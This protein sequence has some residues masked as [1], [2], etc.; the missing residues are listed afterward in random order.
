MNSLPTEENLKKN[1]LVQ[2][3][4]PCAMSY[5]VFPANGLCRLCACFVNRMLYA[6]TFPKLR[7]YRSISGGSHAG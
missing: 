4:V 1:I 7:N 3:L 5:S 2:A 6:E